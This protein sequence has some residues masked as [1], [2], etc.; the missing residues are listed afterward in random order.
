MTFRSKY[1]I[2]GL[3]AILALGAC[4]PAEVGTPEDTATTV[5]E[6][7]PTAPAESQA[8][9]YQGRAGETALVLLG[10]NAEFE[11]SGEGEMSF[12]T[13]INGRMADSGKNEFW[14]FYINDE[15]SEVGAGTYIT[16][17]EDVISWRLETF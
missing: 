14:A 11:A 8:V 2:V 16:A 12:V 9:E 17:D 15:P 5:A 7:S 10:E 4:D 1:C 13:T 6:A 3:I